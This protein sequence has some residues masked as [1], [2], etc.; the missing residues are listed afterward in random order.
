MDDM[1]ND[2]DQADE[3]HRYNDDQEGKQ[4]KEEMDYWK[5]D[6]CDYQNEN[7]DKEERTVTKL[8]WTQQKKKTQELPLFRRQTLITIISVTSDPDLV[9]S[10]GERNL[11]TKSGLALN[12]GQIP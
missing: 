2:D 7:E 5:D 1:Y 3:Q 9:T 6:M 12:R 4:K 11:G 8:G 10:S